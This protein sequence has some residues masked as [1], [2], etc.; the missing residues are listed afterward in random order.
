MCVCARVCVYL[1]KVLKWEHRLH[2]IC[3]GA[4]MIYCADGPRG[5][6]KGRN[7]DRL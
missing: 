7:V 1:H 2:D 5:R 3:K 6:L 4:Y